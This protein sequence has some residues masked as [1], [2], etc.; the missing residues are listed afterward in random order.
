MEFLSRIFSGK[1]DE[2]NCTDLQRLVLEYVQA[3]GRYVD[4]KERAVELQGNKWV[5]FERFWRNTVLEIRSL[6]YVL[7]GV[8]SPVP[9]DLYVWYS[10]RCEAYDALQFY[11]AKAFDN[12]ASDKYVLVADRR[13]RGNVQA[14]SADMTG[15]EDFLNQV[16]LKKA[17]AE[18][19]DKLGELSVGGMQFLGE[20]SMAKSAIHV[21]N[22]MVNAMAIFKDAGSPDCKLFFKDEPLLKKIVRVYHKFR[23]FLIMSAMLYTKNEYDELVD[24]VREQMLRIW[25]PKDSFTPQD[26]EQK[27]KP[28]RKLKHFAALGAG[29]AAAGLL[30][31]SIYHLT[32][33]RLPDGP[34]PRRTEK[35]VKEPVQE[36]KED[37]KIGM[38]M[39]ARQKVMGLWK[40][41]VQGLY[42]INRDFERKSPFY[43]IMKNGIV[44][45]FNAVDKIV[46]YGYLVSTAVSFSLLYY[47]FRFDEVVLTG[48]SIAS[49][50]LTY[51]EDWNRF[52]YVC[53]EE[54]FGR[55]S[56]ILAIPH[57][58]IQAAISVSSRF[59]SF[60]SVFTKWQSYTSTHFTPVIGL[61]G[62]IGSMLPIPYL[63]GIFSLV[64]FAFGDLA[65]LNVRMYM[66]CYDRV[67]RRL[68]RLFGG[69][70]ERFLYKFWYYVVY[71]VVVF[72]FN[73]VN[74]DMLINSMRNMST[75]EQMQ[76]Y[77]HDGSRLEKEEWFA[78]RMNNTTRVPLSPVGNKT[79]PLQ[80]PSAGNT[81]HVP[82]TP[83]G[84][85]TTPL[86]PPRIYFLNEEDVGI[87]QNGRVAIPIDYIN[88]MAR[89][90]PGDKF[91]MCLPNLETRLFN[92]RYP[93]DMGFGQFALSFSLY[94]IDQNMHEDR[95]LAFYQRDYADIECISVKS[96][97]EDIIFGLRRQISLSG[98][99]LVKTDRDFANLLAKGRHPEAV[100][101]IETEMTLKIIGPPFEVTNTSVAYRTFGSPLF[102][103]AR[104]NGNNYVMSF[105]QSVVLSRSF[106]ARLGMSVYGTATYYWE[107]DRGLYVRAPYSVPLITTQVEECKEDVSEDETCSEYDTVN[108]LYP[109]HGYVYYKFMKGSIG[110]AQGAWVF[111][112]WAYRERHGGPVIPQLSG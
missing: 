101:V 45:L 25:F 16:P 60:L 31:Y 57:F 41:V 78:K 111:L 10:N 96:E 27:R 4:Y 102:Q 65:S 26:A 58:L 61:V 36:E 51:V 12:I 86:Q 104:A 13:N 107:N 105:I 103:Q 24:E 21:N 2:Q 112:T 54:W 6:G 84:N 56:R 32:K 108:A 15:F 76:A 42:D 66:I 53:L 34:R 97:G 74:I 82:P 19:T 5:I 79:T 87:T 1:D 35:P 69:P 109:L 71:A 20:I 92:R 18:I 77:F 23:A 73:L 29:A 68:S 49:G 44:A 33:D 99:G 98:D 110:A 91:Y 63:S 81:T 22:L 8:E 39:L 40:S 17:P 75:H 7:H 3:P 83:V 85:K 52:A 28:Q 93:E 50:V 47:G 70:N 88:R 94:E 89:E 48:L 30:G 38:L 59:V 72:H 67:S 9:D 106:W 80:P 46:P 100:K 14:I 55:G 90:V 37:P 62:Q 43:K 64:S 95:V 11:E